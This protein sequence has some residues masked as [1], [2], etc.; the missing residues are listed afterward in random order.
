MDYNNDGECDWT[1]FN[2]FTYPVEVP[3]EH[4]SAVL[5]DDQG[6]ADTSDDVYHHAF[7]VGFNSPNLGRTTNS[8][9]LKRLFENEYGDADKSPGFNIPQALEFYPEDGTSTTKGTVRIIPQDIILS[10][11]TDK[12][13]TIFLEGEGTYEEVSPGIF[14]LKFG[15]KLSNN[16]LFGGTIEVPQ[17]MYNTSNDFDLENLTEDCYQQI[18]L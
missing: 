13:Y 11:K 12:A 14:L 9:N 3:K 18:D 7:R 6:T 17:V 1:K 10:N 2:T 16:E 15:M 8:F 5:F 4:P